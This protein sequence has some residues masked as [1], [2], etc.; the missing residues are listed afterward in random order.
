MADGQTEA[1][2]LGLLERFTARIAAG[3]VDPVLQL[4]APDA[5]IAVAISGEPALRGPGELKTFLQRHA[6]GAA[7]HTWAWSRCEVSATG[8]QASLLAEG[9]ERGGRPYRLRMLCERRDGRWLILQVDGS[10]PPQG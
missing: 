6:Q 2:V 7:R 5:E 9:T 1:A 4:F 8:D 3:E 10:S